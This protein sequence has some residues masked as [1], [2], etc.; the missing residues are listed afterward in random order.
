M[1]HCQV[2]NPVSD[3]GSVAETS[4][5]EG[6]ALEGSSGPKRRQPALEEDLG[7]KCDPCVAFTEGPALLEA[8]AF[9][10]GMLWLAVGTVSV[11]RRHAGAWQ[12]HTQNLCH[13]PPH[14]KTAPFINVI[15]RKFMSLQK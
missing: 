6:R 2:A 7:C 12:N 11:G 4:D 1:G 15:F 14:G 13:Q 8:P 3:F 9:S 10:W 5:Q